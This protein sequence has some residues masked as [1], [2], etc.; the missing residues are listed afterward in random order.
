M[1]TTDTI[2]RLGTWQPATHHGAGR[3]RDIAPVIDGTA[4][5]GHLWRYG[6]DHYRAMLATAGPA[7]C[8]S[9]HNHAAAPGV[10]R[11]CLPARRTCRRP[12]IHLR[13]RRAH[14]RRPPPPDLTIGS[15]LHPLWRSHI[16]HQFTPSR[17]A[18]TRV[19]ISH[20][21]KPSRRNC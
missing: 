1:G 10:R 8:Y 6:P 17:S 15:G 20:A 7:G 13:T 16:T 2:I 19:G 12:P 21:T 5:I 9:A 3:D 11:R 18:F 4:V 14:R